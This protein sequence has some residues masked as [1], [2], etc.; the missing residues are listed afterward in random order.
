MMEKANTKAT[1]SVFW[2]ARKRKS[3]GTVNKLWI[4]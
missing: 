2:N 4:H 1:E 3:K